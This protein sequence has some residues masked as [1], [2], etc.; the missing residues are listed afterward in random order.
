MISKLSQAFVLQIESSAGHRARARGFVGARGARARA[1]GL[2]PL[3]LG[4]GWA[5]WWRAERAQRGF[6]FLCF[7]FRNTTWALQA[8]GRARARCS[9]RVTAR[10]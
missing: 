9:A 3:L 4:P 5:R 7:F 8:T 1:G 2:A 6:I 10:E